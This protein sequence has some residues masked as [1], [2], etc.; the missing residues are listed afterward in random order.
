M[1]VHHFLKW[2]ETA[3][4]SERAAA[5]N[6]LARA[7][8]V[9]SMSFEDRCAAE[10]AL[11]MLL[12][13]PSPKVRLGMAE[14]L[15]LCQ[16][17]PAQ[18]ISSL[19]ADQPEVAAIVL[20]RSPVLTDGFLVDLVAIG[21]PETRRLVA[22]R[23]RLSTALAAALAEIGEEKACL[24]L[25]AN[26]GADLS[27]ACLK[28][29]AE[30]HGHDACV[31]EALLAHR[32]LGPD[33]HYLLVSKLGQALSASPLVRKLMGQ[34]RA[35]KVTREACVIAS[36]GLIE[37]T[38]AADCP[39]LV[40]HLRVSGELT[41]SFLV[42]VVAYGKIDFFG[43]AL[44]ALSGQKE[45]RVRS[46]LADGRDVALEALFRNA[47]LAATTHRV[48]IAAIRIWREVARGK[49]VAGPQEVSWL[50]LRTVGETD[51]KLSTLLS[52]IHV[53][54][55]RENARRHAAELQAA[56]PVPVA[57][58]IASPADDLA[59]IEAIEQQEAVEAVD[60]LAAEMITA[61]FDNFDI[62]AD[63]LRAA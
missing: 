34:P 49:R 50:M 63:E 59:V 9:S 1:I 19:A 23:P 44:V 43:A 27:P 21:S 18:I 22:M 51:S 33:T 7:Y 56:E 54:V 6:A 13:D 8:A 20:V 45:S 58:A 32:N 10:A 37:Q 2:M 35:E 5:A 52:S 62:D 60:D 30:R 25:L 46:L 42:R 41:S 48:L 39:A 40:D 24:E 47:G 4:V 16:H 11:T 53:Q 29:I 12:D 36:V 57:I 38:P 28:R 3:K 15:S 61:E 14:A 55:L 17:A 26:S 31:R